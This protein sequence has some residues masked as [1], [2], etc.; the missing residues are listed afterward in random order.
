MLYTALLL[1]SAG[2]LHAQSTCVQI[3]TEQ[4]DITVMLY[5]ST[6]KHK[7]NFIRAIRSG[8]FNNNEFNRVIK[9]FVSQAG[10][11]DDTILNREGR[12]PELPLRRIPAEIRPGLFHKKGALGAGRNDNPGKASFLNQFYLVAGKIQTDAQL[13]QL[14]A[15]TGHQFSAK[16]RECYKTAGGTPRLDG[17]YTVFGE[18]IEGMAV[19]EKLNALPTDNHDR[20]LRRQK[21][22]LRILSQQE[23]R[24]IPLTP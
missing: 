22:S 1:L 6:P 8:L 16:E 3:R 18:V 21:F 12:H 20:P 24:H 19:A 13:D 7:A 23:L 5:D 9:D 10:E 14:T 4:G 11:L 2:I 17:D 15:K